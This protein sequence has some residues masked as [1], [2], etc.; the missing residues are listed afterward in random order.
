M[1]LGGQRNVRLLNTGD[2]DADGKD[3]FAVM[4]YVPG[5]DDPGAAWQVYDGGTNAA[6]GEWQLRNAAEYGAM[7]QDMCIG[8]FNADGAD[9]L[10]MVRNA[11]GQRLVLAWNILQGADDHRPEG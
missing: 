6:S 7:F 8:D 10:V 3:E 2:F 11:G 9:D 5:A 1:D 4:H